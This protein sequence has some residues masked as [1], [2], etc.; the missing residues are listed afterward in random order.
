LLRTPISA[1][2]YRSRRFCANFLNLSKFHLRVKLN[3][4]STFGISYCLLSVCFAGNSDCES[5]PAGK[6]K[7]PLQ[8]VSHC[9][10]YQTSTGAKCA[11]AARAHRRSTP[12]SCNGLFSLGIP[13]RGSGALAS[14]DPTNSIHYLSFPLPSSGRL[15]RHREATYLGRLLFVPYCMLLT[16]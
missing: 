3:L 4:Y 16:A 11:R 7:R 5:S 9:A 8:A 12:G 15:K 13:Y 1:S 14:P 10:K 6:K 2:Q